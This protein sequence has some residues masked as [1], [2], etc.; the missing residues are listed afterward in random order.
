MR[1]LVLG[2]TL[3]SF[4]TGFAQRI[5]VNPSV[6]WKYIRTQELEFKSGRTYQYEF[7][8]E[9]GYDYIFNLTHNQP[10][11]AVS[12]AIYDLQYKPIDAIKDTASIETRDITFRVKENG[13]YLIMLT[14]VA[15][16]LDAS[17]PSTLTLIRRPTIG[18]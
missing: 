15:G 4:F 10:K 18:Y 8:A 6:K 13:T 9:K 11:A 12:M 5:E 14:L 16:E 2:I 3:F 1:A 17:L 7:P